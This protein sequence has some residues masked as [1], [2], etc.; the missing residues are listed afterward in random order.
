MKKLILSL[1]ALVLSLGLQAQNLEFNQVKIITNQETVPANKVWKVTSV[2]SGTSTS[3]DTGYSIK[4]NGNDVFV[5]EYD[6]GDRFWENIVSI[7]WETRKNGGLSCSNNDNRNIQFVYSGYE[8]ELPFQYRSER[9]NYTPSSYPTNWTTMF[10]ISPQNATTLSLTGMAFGGNTSVRTPDQVEFRMSVQYADGRNEVVDYGP[11][12]YTC[13]GCGG[14]GTVWYIGSGTTS[15][16]EF[17]PT[18]KDYFFLNT[19]LPMWLPAG[20]TLEDGLNTN[21]IS[22][23]EFNVVP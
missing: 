19:Q 16:Y 13:C 18:A 1:G 8:G 2:F 6:S 21:G 23:I 11:F 15:L 7:T 4:V 17:P 22:V 20:A 9:W 5:G 3:Q 14:G 10:T 12:T